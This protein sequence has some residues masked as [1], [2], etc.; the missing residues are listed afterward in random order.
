MTALTPS[1]TIARNDFALLRQD[2]MAPIVLIAMPLVVMEF[3]KPAYGPALQRDGY[4]FATG[5][6]QVVPGMAVMFAFFIV[7]FAGLAFFRE[8][9][10]STWD[11]LRSL[12]VGS[13]QIMIG[14][15][16]PQ[17]LIVAVQQL[18]LFVTGGLLFDLTV[19]GSLVGLVAVDASFALFLMGFVLATVAVCRTFQQVLAV[20]NLG[21]IG[22]AA[23]GG[24]LTPLS[25]LPGWASTI[26]PATPV[27]WAMKGFKH[28]LLD[29]DGLT[30]VLPSVGVLTGAAIVLFAIGARR[31][32]FEDHKGGTLR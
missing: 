19:R 12:P 29:G 28:I 23:I 25:T 27:Y 15:L 20:S 6:E 7:T 8:H 5:A 24:A 30:S 3:T 2:P 18:L 11:R 9:V 21:A 32:R 10:W 16:V 1:A 26:A 22:F 17:F 4:P 13:T 14:K 31:F